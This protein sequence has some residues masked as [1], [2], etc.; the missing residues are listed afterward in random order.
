MAVLRLTASVIA[1]VLSFLAVAFGSTDLVL[2]LGLDWFAPEGS[3]VFSLTLVPLTVC[4]TALF[5]RLEAR[6]WAALQLGPIAARSFVAGLALGVAACLAVVLAQ[7]ALG[8]VRVEGIRPGPAP[9]RALEASVIRNLG[10]GFAEEL[11]FR[12]HVLERLSARVG[13]G[14][15][16][17]V[18]SLL[19]AAGHFRV[20]GFGLAALL[21]LTLLGLLLAGLVRKTG[22]LWASTGFHAAWNIAWSGVF[23][24][25][26]LDAK[27]RGR[28]LLAVQQSCPVS[29]VGVGSLN[30]GGL[31]TILV[32]LAGAAFA[33][34]PRLSAM[35]RA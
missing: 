5:R 25:S 32:L 18:S 2:G 9:W 23:G 3:L 24:L 1:Y 12:G 21:G 28:G 33:L 17:P 8:C 27:G 22:A 20:G 10:I 14:L 11:A 13:F 30:E 31:V 16:A 19:F 4:V 29:L 35:K 34:A 6:P 15:A 7:W 26:M